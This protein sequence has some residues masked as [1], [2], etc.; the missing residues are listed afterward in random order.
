MLI[1]VF[2]G[3]SVASAAPP[4]PPRPDYFW[5]YGRVS[6]DGQNAEPVVQQVIALVEGRACGEATTKVAEDAPGVPSGDVG[7]TVYVVE[8][9]PNG[10]GAGH[11]PGCGT[12]GQPVM[13]YFVGSRR[14]AI[15]EPLFAPGNLRVDVDLRPELAFR[16]FSAMLA[17]DGTD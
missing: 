8:V 12:P 11:R 17:E 13:L 6:V 4:E 9:L 16:L 7:N 15:Q 3:I 5:P 1:L 2:T 10:T 14:I